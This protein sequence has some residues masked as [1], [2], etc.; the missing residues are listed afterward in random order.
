MNHCY[1]G[2]RTS[3]ASQDSSAPRCTQT[4]FIAHWN[5][6]VLI[7]RVRQ[8]TS[9]YSLMGMWLNMRPLGVIHNCD[10]L[11][12]S[13]NWNCINPNTAKYHPSANHLL[14]VI[15]YP[16]VIP[17]S[18]PSFTPVQILSSVLNRLKLAGLSW[19]RFVETQVLENISQAWNASMLQA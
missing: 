5:A 10:T 12:A 1:L 14:P 4:H 17:F 18:Y 19:G 15:T 6:A 9:R 7:F 16:H 3:S 2:K 13:Y 11:I 8:A